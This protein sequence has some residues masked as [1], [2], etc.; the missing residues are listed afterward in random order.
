MTTEATP[1]HESVERASQEWGAEL[2]RLLVEV[3]KLSPV[4]D[5][6]F[7]VRGLLLL[8]LRGL[9]A[10][11]AY[12]IRKDERERLARAAVELFR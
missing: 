8:R 10:D 7:E 2:D 3:M 1:T 5:S 4:P 9:F 12:V 11:Q 6:I